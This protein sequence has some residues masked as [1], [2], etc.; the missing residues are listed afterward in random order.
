MSLCKN[1]GLKEIDLLIELNNEGVNIDPALFRSL[2]YEN[3]YLEQI[4]SCFDWNFK[5]Y[6][7]S[8]IPSGFRFKSSSR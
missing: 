7:A 3:T 4:R 5:T 2:D 8:K 1:E 6:T